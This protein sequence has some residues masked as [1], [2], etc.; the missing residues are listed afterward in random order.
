MH[1][2]TLENEDIKIEGDVTMFKIEVDT[3]LEF[4]SRELVGPPRILFSGEF[5]DRYTVTNKGHP[6]VWHEAMTELG[7][8]SVA[9][10]RK[11][12][13]APEHSQTEI[14]SDGMVKFRWTA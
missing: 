6:T 3:D 4:S 12:V 10:A 2:L 8:G 7:T 13:G 9:Q 11:R 14:L 5:V 1:H